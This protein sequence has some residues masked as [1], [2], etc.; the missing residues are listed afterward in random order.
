MSASIH[1]S[2]WEG[3]R[4]R[5][6][7]KRPDDYLHSDEIE[8]VL[9][10]SL[11]RDVWTGVAEVYQLVEQQAELTEA[12]W[13]PA[14]SGTSDPR[15][16]RNVRNFLQSRKVSGALEWDGDGRYRL[17][18]ATRMSVGNDTAL[19]TDTYVAYWA[20]RI[21]QLGALRRDDWRQELDRLRPTGSSTMTTSSSSN[22][23]SRIQNAVTLHRDRGSGSSGRGI[24][25]RR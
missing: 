3:A 19:D 8:R 1:L 22:G 13:Q 12:D 4:S 24:S 14:A 5:R 7:A 2:H 10:P 9:Y 15:W 25:P 20:G 6:V 17:S 23:T 11:A 18:G 16:Q 21:E